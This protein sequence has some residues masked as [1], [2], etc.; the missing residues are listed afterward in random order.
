MRRLRDD[1]LSNQYSRGSAVA[2]T[3]RVEP[4]GDVETWS[5]GQFTGKWNAVSGIVVLVDPSPCNVADRK[6]FPGPGFEFTKMHGYV[7]V[8]TC[9]EFGAQDDQ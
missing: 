1:L 6:V 7:A 4:T 3:P 2:Y 5:L 8:L 9:T